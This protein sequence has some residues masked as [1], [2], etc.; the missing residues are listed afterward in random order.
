MTDEIFKAEIN[1]APVGMKDI[2]QIGQIRF[3]SDLNLTLNP[4]TQIRLNL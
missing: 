4:V 3:Y 1:I 2:F